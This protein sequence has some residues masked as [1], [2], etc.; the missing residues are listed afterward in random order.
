MCACELLDEKSAVRRAFRIIRLAK[1]GSYKN[2]DFEA[3]QATASTCVWAWQGVGVAW[4][5]GMEWERMEGRD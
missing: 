5:V 1:D 2:V 3:P 4:C